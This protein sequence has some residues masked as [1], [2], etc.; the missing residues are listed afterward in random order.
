MHL[1]QMH[2]RREVGTNIKAKLDSE[3]K[4]RLALS[5]VVLFFCAVVGIIFSHETQ[6]QIKTTKDL[7]VKLG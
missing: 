3:Q 1:I 7:Y 6:K 4:A 2:I 5:H